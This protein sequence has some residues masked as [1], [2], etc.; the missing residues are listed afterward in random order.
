MAKQNT[1]SKAKLNTEFEGFKVN[2]EFDVIEMNMFFLPNN[3]KGGL[4]VVLG[5][6]S[7]LRLTYPNGDKTP[8][9]SMF[10]LS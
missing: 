3:E 8:F 1:P 10:D 2:R 9:Y 7:Y 4:C 6:M 5:M